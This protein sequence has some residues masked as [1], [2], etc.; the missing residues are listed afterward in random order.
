MGMYGIVW[1]NEEGLAG[2]QCHRW[3]RVEDAELISTRKLF[4]RGS[5][6]VNS[7]INIYAI[8]LY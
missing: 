2:T 5:R 4:T 6:E 8:N 7:T 3:K 1:V